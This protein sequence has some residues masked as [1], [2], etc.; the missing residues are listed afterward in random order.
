MLAVSGRWYVVLIVLLVVVVWEGL[1]VVMGG[2][3]IMGVFPVSSD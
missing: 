2:G 3:L 1:E